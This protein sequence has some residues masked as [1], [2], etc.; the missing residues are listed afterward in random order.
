MVARRLQRLLEHLYDLDGGPDVG[1]FLVTDR[2]ALLG[3]QPCNDSRRLDEQLLLAQ[4]EDGAAVS[5]YIDA[6]VLSRLERRDPESALDE[7]NLPDFCTV[8]EGVSHFLYATWRLR[9]DHPLSLLELE[10]QAE[11]DKFALT[12]L[13]LAQQREGSHPA[14]AFGWLFEAVRFDERLTP[15]QLDRYQCAHHSAARYCRFLERRFVRRGRA[16]MPPM[17][18][19]LRRFY[20][21]G[22]S[23]KLD[24]AT[25]AA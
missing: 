25:C 23:A 16:V 14:H 7:R 9:Q 1:D 3:L 20:R 17:L 6:A 11:V 8:L 24:H 4:T 22:H 21:L 10:T 12:V 13:L 15:E 19:E 18:R 2:R 5:L